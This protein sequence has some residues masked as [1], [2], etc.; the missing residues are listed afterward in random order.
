MEEL[1]AKLGRY[2]CSLQFQDLSPELILK[3]TI[4]EN[5]KK[6]GFDQKS[7]NRL[8]QG[9]LFGHRSGALKPTQISTRLQKFD[10]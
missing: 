7:R 6:I 2:A 4:R 9:R 8:K 1:L 10:K 3:I 5:V